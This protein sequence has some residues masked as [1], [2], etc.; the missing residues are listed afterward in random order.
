MCLIFSFKAA[1]EGLPPPLQED[2]NVAD[3]KIRQSEALY[4]TLLAEEAA[5]QAK[6]EGEMDH[7]LSEE[8][9]RQESEKLQDHL[10]C[11]Q[12]LVI[13]VPVYSN[14]SVGDIFVEFSVFQ[15]WLF[16][17]FHFWFLQNQLA[18]QGIITAQQKDELLRKHL[19]AEQNLQKVHNHQRDSQISHLKDKLAER[20]KRKLAKLR[21][22]QEQELSDV[23]N[24]IK[25]F[26]PQYFFS[27]WLCISDQNSKTLDHWLNMR[28]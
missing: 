18:Q 27:G 9:R 22:Q 10:V 26:F 1:V 12:N 13:H 17:Y 2:D 24:S 19:E 25:L 28:N 11:I 15:L 4:D 23:T 16:F 20:R 5:G 7:Q 14:Q 21:A 6:G 8:K 3:T